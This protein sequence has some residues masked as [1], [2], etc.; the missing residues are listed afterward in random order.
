LAEGEAKIKEGE[1]VEVV[2]VE[3]VRLVVK[4]KE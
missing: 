2:E 1:Q 3:G 4:L